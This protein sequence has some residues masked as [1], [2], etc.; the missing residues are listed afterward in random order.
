MPCYI[1]EHPKTKKRIEISQGMDAEHIYIDSKNVKWDRVFVN[2]QVN[3]DV[4][5]LDPFNP[6]DFN[7]KTASKN[8]KVGK[9]FERSKEMSERRK[10]K[11]GY[12]PVKEKWMKDYSAKRGNKP[13][14]KKDGNNYFND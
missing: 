11:L 13:Y 2:P 10:D 6:A 5:A 7:R 3:T 1:F 9:L 12:D 14:P 4:V 8:D